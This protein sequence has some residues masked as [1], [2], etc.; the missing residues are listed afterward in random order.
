MLT[1]SLKNKY[2]VEDPAPE[3]QPEPAAKPKPGPKKNG[4]AKSKS[5]PQ[6]TKRKAAAPAKKPVKKR[7]TV[8]SSDDE[9]DTSRAGSP[10]NH[11]SPS[12]A[13]SEPPRKAVRRPQRVV[14]ED[15]EESLDEGVAEAAPQKTPEP[16]QEGGSDS[17]MSVLI[18]ESPVKNKRQRKSAANKSAKPKSKETKAAKTKPITKPSK[19]KDDDPDQAEIKRLQGWL[20]KCG[21]RKVWSKELASYDTAKEKIKHLKAMLKDAGM[22]GKY[23]VE[24]AARIKEERELAKDLEA[25]REGER[26]W[27]KVEATENGGRPK[28]RAA[29][30]AATRVKI[31]DPLEDEDALSGEGEPSKNDS[32]TDDDEDEDG[33][34]SG[35]D[36]EHENEVTSDDTDNDGGD[37]FE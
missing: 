19:A 12:E 5:S 4:A 10:A 18:D 36:Q 34:H 8:V 32:D 37:D 7:K 28:R 14:D 25:I 16:N 24:K 11:D 1:P 9:S 3:P 33:D 35:D 6:G 2:C 29:A 22:D 21:I 30:L 31:T 23:S 26:Q 13:E 15:P 20:V 17:E 27:G